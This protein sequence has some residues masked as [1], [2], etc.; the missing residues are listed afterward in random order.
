MIPQIIILV[1]FLLMSNSNYAEDAATFQGVCSQR[2][3]VA[4]A[5]QT[6]KEGWLFLTGD[7]HF[8]GCDEFWGEKA[9]R[10]SKASKPEWA[11]PLPVIVNFQE[12][13]S[14]AG[15]ELW[16]VPVPPKPAIYA[17]KVLEHLSETPPRFDTSLQNFYT[18]L[19]KNGVKVIDLSDEFLASRKTPTTLQPL[20]CM[21]DSHW[22]PWACELVAQR[23][24]KELGEHDWLPKAGSSIFSVKS[25]PLEVIGD[26]LAIVPEAPVKKET[27]AARLITEKETVDSNSPILLMGDSHCLVFHAG[28]DLHGTQGGLVDQLAF[29]LNMPIDLLGVRGSG[30]TATRVNLLQRIKDDAKYL[31]GKKVIIWCFA[32]REFTES[33]G[34]RKVPILK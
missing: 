29:E 31:G 26:L 34:W 4:L 28:E 16:L 32:A 20:Y 12:Q 5:A 17:D 14:K 25:I 1:I 21:T 9:A 30:A 19:K 10:V 23:I 3:Q 15:V 11:D 24:K 6:G 18:E 8:L 13:L 2:G 22:S 7:F 33:Q 27:L